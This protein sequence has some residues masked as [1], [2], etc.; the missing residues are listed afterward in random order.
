MSA[1]TDNTPI[2]AL[3][4]LMP[5]R[6][7]WPK[8]ERRLVDLE[9]PFQKGRTL[10]YVLTPWFRVGNCRS[11]LD[12]RLVPRSRYAD[13]HFAARIWINGGGR[14]HELR[15]MVYPPKRYGDNGRTWRARECPADR[16]PMHGAANDYQH[17]P[18]LVLAPNE[19][20]S[21]R[22][23]GPRGIYMFTTDDVLAVMRW[24]DSLIE[25]WLPEVPHA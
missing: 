8:H 22:D 9:H 7:A 17:T 6:D 14:D 18:G 12:R 10:R 20:F 2:Q 19:G 23:I 21:L 25:A 5:K 3:L 13:H 24:A 16:I 4:N 15:F 1:N 11:M